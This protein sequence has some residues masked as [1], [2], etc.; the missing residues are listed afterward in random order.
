MA[1]PANRTAP[2]E[3]AGMPAGIP[4][5]VGNEAAER[6]NFYGMRA[7]LVVF[8]TQYL[9]SRTGAP[10]PMSE[11]E[12]DKWYHVFVASNYF[13]PVF[14]AILA[15]ALWGKYR[16]IFWLS[17]VYCFGSFALALDNT[18]LGLALGLS[19][20][21]IG[22]GGIKPCVS[23]NVGDQFGP[24]NQHLISRAFGWFYFS[25]NAGSSFSIMLIPWLL[26][27]Y[28]PRVAFA[29]PG[30]LMV[31]A[32]LIF[33]MGR[34][35]FI[36]IA[37]GGRAFLR[38]TFSRD[39]LATLGRLAVIYVFVAVFWSLWDQTGGEWV[40]QAAKMDLHF[41]WITWL[42]SQFQVVNAILILVFIPLFQYVIYPAVSRVFPLTPL[43]KIGLGLLVA[44]A[45]FLISAWIDTQI[46]AGLKPNIGWQLPAYALITAAEIMVSIT[47]LEFSYTQ[48]PKRMKSI[49]MAAYLLSITGGNAFTALVHVVIQN[50]DGSL[51]LSGPSYYLFFAGLSAAAAV[52]F[53]FVAMGYRGRTH[54]QDAL[55]ADAPPS[56]PAPAA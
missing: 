15:D 7:I 10:A 28:G 43:R 18:R 8:M 45:S 26:Q 23:A 53:A 27:H 49:V 13:F 1:S 35:K 5:I 56:A 41:A 50:P 20:I 24:S 17:F 54:L 19:L 12:A 34:R 6:F 36:H 48:A 47:S 42:P 25:V 33:W 44:G 46:N 55:P 40:L 11:N 37:P 3:T 30:A 4:Y 21:A 32:T 52:V 39:G 22:S 2:V 51:K 31:V 29:V 16:T 9:C 14:G 38:D